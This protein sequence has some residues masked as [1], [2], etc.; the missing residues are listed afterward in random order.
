MQ[1]F[2]ER[3]IVVV[4]PA[5]RRGDYRSVSFCYADSNAKSLKAFVDDLSTALAGKRVAPLAISKAMTQHFRSV[6]LAGPL[7]MVPSAVDVAAWDA[8]SIACDLPL[9]E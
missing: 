8:L 5:Y 9:A 2:S 1:D 6:G 7:L 4:G 3:T